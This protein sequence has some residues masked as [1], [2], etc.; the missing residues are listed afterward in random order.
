[1]NRFW[2]K[3]CRE[4]PTLVC[5]VISEQASA[6]GRGLSWSVALAR[7]CGREANKAR[8]M[9]YLA[10][11]NV[12]EKYQRSSGKQ[13][14]TEML[15]R[16][17]GLASFPFKCVP[18]SSTVDSF[19]VDTLDLPQKA[20]EACS[21][22]GV[23]KSSN[24]GSSLDRAWSDMHAT[25]PPLE[26]VAAP[27]SSSQPCLG[28]GMCVCRGEGQRVHQLRGRIHR[29]MKRDLGSVQAKQLLMEGHV[30]MQLCHEPPLLDGSSAASSS[31]AIPTFFFHLGLMYLK[32]YRATYHRVVPVEKPA[33]EP[34]V[35][36]NVIFVEV[37]QT[38]F[39]KCLLKQHSILPAKRLI[40]PKKNP[41]QYL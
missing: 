13:K 40:L 10:N 12:S 5:R 26:S 7:H 34:C 19:E 39:S 22:S 21:W 3:H 30:V 41:T 4:Q 35:A 20:I 15:E 14:V 38:F 36:T 28:Y 16:V 29:Q 2:Q 8:R 32:P 17:P 33:G 31:N 24:F 25:I 9:E 11:I 6:S 23:Q 37:R 1:M 18:C 27:A